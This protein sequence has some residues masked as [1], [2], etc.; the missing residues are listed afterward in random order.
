MLVH[1][2]SRRIGIG[3]L[4]GGGDCR[5]IGSR[6]GLNFPMPSRALPFTAVVDER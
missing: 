5:G 4:I 1:A 3:L 6:I 2:V